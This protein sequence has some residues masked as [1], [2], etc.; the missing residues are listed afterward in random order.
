M[1]KHEE[2]KAKHHQ[3]IEH[4]NTY[5]DK[6]HPYATL[7]ESSK[8]T[9]AYLQTNAVNKEDQAQFLDKVYQFLLGRV[10]D[11]ATR[12]RIYNIIAVDVTYQ[13]TY[14]KHK[15]NTESY[16]PELNLSQLH[17]QT[18]DQCIDHYQVGNRTG[19]C[20]NVCQPIHSF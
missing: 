9:R 10:R 15:R 4:Y 6:V 2:I 5:G 17:A 18:D 8:E 7:L 1:I 14:E 16:T 11:C 13:D 3:D 20:N 12:S 19:I